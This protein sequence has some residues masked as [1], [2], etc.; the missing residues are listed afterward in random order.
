MEFYEGDTLIDVKDAAPYATSW[1]PGSVGV[2]HLSA[3]AVDADG[4]GNLS[5][6]ARVNAHGLADR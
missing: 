2:Y 6:V 4:K 1:T 5:R 3:R